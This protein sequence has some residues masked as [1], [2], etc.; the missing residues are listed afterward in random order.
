MRDKEKHAK[1]KLE[2]CL[3]AWRNNREE[4]AS[5]WTRRD[6]ARRVQVDRHP[7]KRMERDEIQRLLAVEEEMSRSSSPSAKP[8]PLSAR[9][10][11]ARAPT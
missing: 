4:N 7:L 3:T 1:E 5:S 10:S 8:S 11:A 9:R 2:S 6:P